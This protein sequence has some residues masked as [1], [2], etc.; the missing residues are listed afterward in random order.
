MVIKP[1]LHEKK[2]NLK[3]SGLLLFFIPLIFLFPLTLIERYFRA[4][5]ENCMQQ[6]AATCFFV[7]VSLF[8]FFAL[9]RQ[10]AERLAGGRLTGRQR[11]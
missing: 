10:E 9:K 11:V 6:L 8:F 1:L 5:S 3:T 4:G 2:K 7:L